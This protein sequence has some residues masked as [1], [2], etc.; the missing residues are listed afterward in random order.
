MK[1]Q[2]K[3][4]LEWIAGFE[5]RIT[6]IKELRRD[7]AP[8]SFPFNYTDFV[9]ECR[10][11]GDES[12]RFNFF[13][14]ALEIFGGQYEEMAN[15]SS[16]RAKIDAGIIDWMDLQNRRLEAWDTFR[17]SA[18][19]ALQREMDTCPRGVPRGDKNSLQPSVR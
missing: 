14:A 15:A 11:R 17:H 7:V 4:A 2:S 8:E 1:L 13:L 10:A 18:K 16:D 3:S 5:H 6:E 12:P 9:A 19:Q